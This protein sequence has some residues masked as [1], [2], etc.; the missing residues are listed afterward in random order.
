MDSFEKKEIYIDTPSGDMFLI[1]IINNNNSISL[2]IGDYRL[3]LQTESAIDLAD[4]ILTLTSEME[5]IYV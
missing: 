4:A 1:E 2:S 3:D 5:R